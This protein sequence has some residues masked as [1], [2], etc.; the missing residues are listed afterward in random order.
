MSESEAT[1]TSSPLNHYPPEQCGSLE[2]Q[3]ELNE[4]S[5]TTR[6]PLDFETA[7]SEEAARNV[8]KIE[9]AMKSSSSSLHLYMDPAWQNEE[10]YRGGTSDSWISKE[11]SYMGGGLLD[12]MHERNPR[13]ISKAEAE[14]MIA[15]I[16][17]ERALSN[18]AKDASSAQEPISLISSPSDSLGEAYYDLEAGSARDEGGAAND[19]D[20]VMDIYG[21]IPEYFEDVEDITEE[22]VKEVTRDIDLCNYGYV[23]EDSD[24][25]AY[26]ATPPP[27][28]PPPAGIGGR[29]RHKRVA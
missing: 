1:S 19:E 6:H 24:V 26:E 11:P 10:Y 13:L 4:M 15:K 2:F 29:G 7:M 20:D 23:P 17:T 8:E 12:F 18:R 16:A 5:G 28:P 27:P 9:D 14:E 25:E 22:D 3:R 21:A